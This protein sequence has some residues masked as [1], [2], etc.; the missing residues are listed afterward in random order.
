M[1]LLV[2]FLVLFN[3]LFSSNPCFAGMDLEGDKRIELI[4]E[5]VLSDHQPIND[6][7]INQTAAK[8]GF[9]LTGTIGASQAWAT[10]IDE[11][12]HQQWSYM[13]PPD[14]PAQD[15]L[16]ST[17]WHS[18]HYE[19]AADLNGGNTLLCGYKDVGDDRKP[20][21]LGLLTRIDKSGGLVNQQLLYPQN[22]QQ[23]KLNYIRQ[24]AHWN[25]GYVIFG[26]TAR[27]LPKVQGTPSPAL[28][29]SFYWVIKLDS[30]GEIKWEKL[31]PKKF[32]VGS[33]P[34]RNPILIMKNGDLVVSS[35]SKETNEKKT[36]VDYF[37]DVVRFNP[38]GEIKVRNKFPGR[39]RLVRQPNPAYAIRLAPD[40]FNEFGARLLTLND[41]LSEVEHLSIEKK[42]EFGIYQATE[43][44]NHSIVFSGNFD[45]TNNTAAMIGYSP[46]FSLRQ[47]YEFHP[48][49]KSWWVEDALATG[50]E[51]EWVTIRT[52]HDHPSKSETNFSYVFSIF[53][54]VSH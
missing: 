17:A 44:P 39:M 36:G 6:L 11:H 3:S 34:K 28:R 33:I 38:E 48:K 26:E 54:F 47:E 49:N 50:I 53:N 9:V 46:N 19:S 42:E 15:Q 22:N 16:V 52:I 2:S 30:L 7:S 27:Y 41:D 24:C 40:N 51:N 32:D 8:D 5:I 14:I 37:T 31:I 29:E 12:G 18:S 21:I 25:D 13:F 10:R 45:F 1:R 35:T 23:F 43:L 20:I 4:H